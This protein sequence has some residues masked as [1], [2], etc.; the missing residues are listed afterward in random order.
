[1]YFSNF[2]DVFALF[3]FQYYKIQ[4]QYVQKIRNP[5]CVRLYDVTLHKNFMSLHYTIIIEKICNMLYTRVNPHRRNVYKWTLSYCFILFPLSLN[6]P[7]YSDVRRGRS[8]LSYNLE[9]N[10]CF[11]V[12]SKCG[13]YTTHIILTSVYNNDNY[14]IIAII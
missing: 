12:Y 14:A 11:S 5:A 10:C 9:L 6:Q 1:M 13:E 3:H 7:V 2:F 4:F 8:H